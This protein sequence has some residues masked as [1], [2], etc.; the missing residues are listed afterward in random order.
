MSHK[1]LIPVEVTADQAENFE[2]FISNV[3]DYHE[4][5]GA[6]VVT[7]P[8]VITTLGRGNLLWKLKSK[9]Q[10]KKAIFN[11]LYELNTRPNPR[12]LTVKE[13]IATEK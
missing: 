12:E 9:K 11:G 7:Q 8:Q 6:M 1:Q 4:N 3:S 5:I 2:D 10:H 13:W